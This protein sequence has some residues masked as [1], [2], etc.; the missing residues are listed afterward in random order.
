MRQACASCVQ[1]DQNPAAQLGAA[2]GTW[3]AAGRDKLT[4]IA[5]QEFS[6]FGMWLEQLIAE[7]TG[8]LGKGIVP[9]DGEPAGTPEVYGADRVF[10]RI[11]LDQPASAP[12]SA[13][14]D[15]AWA[16]RIVQAGHPVITITLRDRYEIGQEFFR[17]EFATA[18]AGAVLHINPFDEPN[19]QESKDN[20][21]RVIQ[22]FLKGG[23]KAAGL[24]TAPTLQDRATSLSVYSS[25]GFRG[26]DLGAA[27]A[28]WFSAVHSGDYFDL[29]VYLAPTDQRQESLRK[30]R[31]AVRDQLR[32][33]T[34]LGYGPRFL[35][36]TGQLHKGG[37]NT[38]VFLQ[39]TGKPAVD[40][41][42]PGQTYSFGTL[43]TAQ[44][45]G[46]FQS[47]AAHD[48]RVLRIDLGSDIDAGLKRLA[49]LM[50]EALSPAATVSSAGR[51]R[52]PA[53]EAVG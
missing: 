30:L 40:L 8:K 28:E 46:D 17:W 52:G 44:A 2:I 5:S 26:Q 25:R 10:V 34:T 41:E 51:P 32:V 20:T 21:N 38:G 19:V 35:H 12:A 11:V 36:S 24:E 50:S 29:M 39:V 16:R 27:L 9:V 23:A 18:V 15:D 13:G 3:A 22:S 33:A 48:R 31:T 42:I 47:L 37:P 53:T 45:L 4:L 1:A 49:T 14:L 6:S 7:S 43:F